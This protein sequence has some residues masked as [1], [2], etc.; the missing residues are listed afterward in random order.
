MNR[1]KQYAALTFKIVVAVGLIYWIDK[2]GFLNLQV[3]RNLPTHAAVFSVG[4]IFL[5]IFLNNVR[6]TLLLRARKFSAS[7]R[8]T[9]PLTLIG[10][11]FNFAMPGGV[12]GDVVKGYYLLQNQQDRK[13]DAAMSILADRFI[14]LFT[15]ALMAL[16]AMAFHWKFIEQ[17]KELMAFLWL[18]VG[19]FIASF[20]FLKFAFSETLM[21]K[22]KNKI[23]QIPKPVS[24]IYDAFHSYRN[25]KGALLAAV[26]ISV[27]SQT[28]AIIFFMYLNAQIGDGLVTADQLLWIVPI[29]LI[30][31]SLPISP[32]GVGVG[33]AVFLILFTWAQGKDSPLGPTLITGY[34]I[35]LLLVGLTGIYFYL[36][37]R[38]QGLPNVKR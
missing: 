18:L 20:V 3:Y 32:G 22:L 1:I 12:G 5:S 19:L 16:V 27:V 37:M 17:H 34:Q 29:G 4:L 26:G 8:Q 10:L 31:T 24:R 14:G 11:I 25:M 30:A 9:L 35:S 28:I 6:W 33:Q 7:N 15:M 13:L 38:K 21:E 2:K 36:R 23:H